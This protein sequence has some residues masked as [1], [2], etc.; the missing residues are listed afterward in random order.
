M[1]SDIEKLNSLVNDLEGQ[2][3]TLNEFNGLL[4]AVDKAHMEIV[5]TKELLEKTSEGYEQYAQHLRQNTSMFE[6]LTDAIATLKLLT[7]EHFDATTK[8][9]HDRLNEH[10]NEL[11]SRTEQAYQAN[12]ESLIK[13]LELENR[14]RNLINK[15]ALLGVLGG[16]GLS[17]ISYVTYTF[18]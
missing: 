7:P 9:N 2:A 17:A 10:L 13:L 18:I 5:S 4:T 8:L 16:I 11:Q 6:R 14:N 3:Q 1:A 15:V 12:R